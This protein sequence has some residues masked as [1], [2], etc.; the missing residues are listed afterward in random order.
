M[1]FM[2]AAWEP[3]EKHERSTTKRYVLMQH[4]GTT[5]LIC[6]HSVGELNLHQQ[7]M[8]SRKNQKGLELDTAVAFFEYIHSESLAHDSHDGNLDKKEAGK[9]APL[10][11]RIQ[12]E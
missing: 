7:K 2:D 3:G 9:H 11:G 10:I 1:N 8:G 5:S 12:G 4:Y 6:A